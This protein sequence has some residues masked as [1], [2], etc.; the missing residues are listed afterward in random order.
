MSHYFN[1][2][3]EVTIIQGDVDGI[4]TVAPIEGGEVRDV[5]TLDI[6]VTDP[7]DFTVTLSI[8]FTDHT[9]P[10]DAARTFFKVITEDIKGRMPLTYY[11]KNDDTGEET[12][13]ELDGEGN[14]ITGE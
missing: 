6:E 11:V 13:V 7:G 12:S 1:N 3:Q 5:K 14:I 9:S 4:S 2:G 10:E 8:P